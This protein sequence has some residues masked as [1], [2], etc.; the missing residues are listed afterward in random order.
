MKLI[1]LDIDG[2]LNTTQNIKEHHKKGL[3]T[4]S[5]N[6]QLPDSCLKNLQTLVNNTNAK[7]VVSSSWRIPDYRSPAI[8]NLSKQLDKYGLDIYGFTPI[9]RDLNL[10][11]GDE[12][13]DYIN[14]LSEPVEGIVI[15]D[16][17]EDMC[18]FRKRYLVHCKS[19]KGF[20]EKQLNYAL[21]VI[22][23]KFKIQYR[24]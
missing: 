2:V 6:I 16:D 15:L 8:R 11:R 17:D 21:Q 23:R 18:E 12:I 22:N 7:I 14:S 24:Q 19:D 20:G 13:R 9:Y 5:Y 3:S 4:S 10:K 1:F